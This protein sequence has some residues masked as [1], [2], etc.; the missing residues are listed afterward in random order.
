MKIK[1]YLGI[2]WLLP[3]FQLSITLFSIRKYIIY[4]LSLKLLFVCRNIW[5]YIFIEYLGIYCLVV[6]QAWWSHNNI[7][8]F[9]R[10][11]K[12]NHMFVSLQGRHVKTGQ[13]AAIKCM[14]VTGVSLFSSLLQYW[15]LIM[16]RSCWGLSQTRC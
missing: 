11:P 10:F 7:P 16:R 2:S 1:P 13:L 14:D 12:H 4:D 8:S 9:N 6:S 3:V 5:S 15:P